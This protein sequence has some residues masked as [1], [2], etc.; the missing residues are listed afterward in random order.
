MVI[1]Y[2]DEE[3]LYDTF[4]NEI[5]GILGLTHYDPDNLDHAQWLKNR[6]KLLYVNGGKAMCLYS[7]Y[8]MPLGFLVFTYDKGIE[9]LYYNDKANIN[10]FGVKEYHRNKGYGTTLLRELES[11]LRQLGAEWIYVDTYDN[12][13]DRRS[14]AFYVKNGFTPIACFPDK[15]IHFCKRL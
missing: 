7:D 9:N 13:E 6:I 5:I 14:I 10:W 4:L 2:L 8:N 1:K 3:T 15:Q 12:K 11:H